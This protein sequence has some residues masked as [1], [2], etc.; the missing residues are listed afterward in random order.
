MVARGLSNNS[1][2][3]IGHDVH[4]TPP[5]YSASSDIVPW[6]RVA[7]ASAL[8]PYSAYSDVGARSGDTGASNL[9][10][11]GH[12]ARHVPPPYSTSLDAGAWIRVADATAPPP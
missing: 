2:F 7:D 3:A 1:F 8:A 10:S 5:P 6:F 9:L 11:T 4:P 12:A